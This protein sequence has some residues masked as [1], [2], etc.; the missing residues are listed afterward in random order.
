MTYRPGSTAA[1]VSFRLAAVLAVC[2]AISACNDPSS[3]DD[4][5]SYDVVT[6]GGDHSCALAITGEAY[7]WGA[8]LEG[9]LGTGTKEIRN[10]PGAVAG[11]LKFEDI[12]AGEDHTCAIAVDS[13]AYC[14]GWN[15]FFQR[16]N[17]SD[18]RDTEPVPVT[19]PAG[20]LFQSVSAGAYHNCALGTDS[21]AYCWGQN[22]YGQAGNGTTNT[23]P[24]AMAVSSGLR[25]KQVTSGAWH[26]CGVTASGL[27]Y[28]W[29]RNDLGQLGSGSTALFS[30]TPTAIANLRFA[31]VD[32]GTSHT[33]G[34][35]SS[36]ELYC[37]GSS[38]HGEL[39]QGSAFKP[40]LAGATT[41]VRVSGITRA[42][43]I[44]AGAYHT[45]ASDGAGRP[46][47]WGKGEYGQLANG[48]TSDQYF[49]QPIA[50]FNQQINFSDFGLGGTHHACGVLERAIFC[51]GTGQRGQLGARDET[52]AGLPQR[53]RN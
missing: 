50:L 29:G 5:R 17:S 14:W 19:A 16:G 43:D 4:V 36:G 28:C 8:G 45:C 24:T 39:G 48:S 23:T 11:G 13:K 27:A 44:A 2:G 41:P 53:V 46:W 7:C 22:R 25:F 6:T 49:P 31:K 12:S 30:T 42:N 40:G 52:Y 20:V 34:V 38:Q 37:W 3:A 26:S 33:C 32:A 15:G 51:W 35:V 47:C 10:T 18:P 21:L 9:E 1:S